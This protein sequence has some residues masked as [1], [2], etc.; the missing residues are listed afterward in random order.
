MPNEAVRKVEN[1]NLAQTAAELG[2]EDDLELMDPE[3]LE[4]LWKR[5]INALEEKLQN[6]K[7]GF[8]TR[9]SGYTPDFFSDMIYVK[10][11]KIKLPTV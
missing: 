5:E 7:E 8:H 1:D 6:F 3:A 10:N 2:K 9:F 11:M 4:Q